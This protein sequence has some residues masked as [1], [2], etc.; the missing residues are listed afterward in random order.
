MQTRPMDK[1]I[2]INTAIS[3]IGKYWKT[4]VLQNNKLFLTGGM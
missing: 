3:L 1:E 4:I 2:A